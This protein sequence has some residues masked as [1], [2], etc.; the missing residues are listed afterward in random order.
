MFHGFSRAVNEKLECVG[1][2]AESVL[3]ILQET[4]TVAVETIS[5]LPLGKLKYHENLLHIYQGASCAN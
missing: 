4:V 5:S 3:G 1:H 2:N